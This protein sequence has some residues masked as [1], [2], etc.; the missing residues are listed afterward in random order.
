MIMKTCLKCGGPVK[1]EGNHYVCLRCI[2]RILIEE[3][4]LHVQKK[5]VTSDEDRE[6]TE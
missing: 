4:S 5:K 1:R 6:R 3:V 2:W